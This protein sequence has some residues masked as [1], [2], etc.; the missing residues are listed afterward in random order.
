MSPLPSPLQAALLALGREGLAVS[1]PDGRIAWANPAF[2]ALWGADPVG[3]DLLAAL[4]PPRDEGDGEDGDEGATAADAAAWRTALARDLAARVAA[5]AADPAAGEAASEAAGRAAAEG[6]ARLQVGADGSPGIPVSWRLAAAMGH[7]LWTLSDL[8]PLQA[9]QAQAARGSALLEA[10]QEFG[11]LGV[12]ERDLRTGHGHWDRHVFR[13]FGL[14]PAQGTPSFEQAR[15]RIHPEDRG[16][17]DFQRSTTRPGR[18]AQRFRV[19]DGEGRLRWIHSQWEVV[20]DRRGRPRV[21]RGV[22]VDDSEAIAAARSLDE[23][24]AQLALALELG[25]IV[26][27]RHDLAS[28]RLYYNPRGYE[29]LAMPYRP[30]GLSLAEVR[31][32]IHP[33]DLPAVVDAAR[34][35]LVHDVPTDM[36]ARYRRSDGSWRHVLTRRVLQRDGAGRP[37]AFLGVALDI[38][39]QREVRQQA[40]RL[41]RQLENAASAAGIGM[42]TRD[43]QSDETHWDPETYRLYGRA[44]ALGP[45]SRE[46]WLQTYV[47]PDDRERMRALRARQLAAPEQVFEHEFRVI[48]GDG[49]LRWFAQRVRLEPWEGRALVF[50]ATLDVTERRRADQA[51]RDANDRVALATRAAG[52]GT[53]EV[54]LRSGEVRWDAQMYALRGLPA[55]AGEVAPALSPAQ[56]R[57]AL[58]HPDELALVLE[59]NRRS[60]E[61]GAM[62]S[63]EFRV[64]WP[65]GSYRWLASRSVPVYDDA[66]RAVRQIGVNLDIQE[67]VDAETA[68]REALAAQRQSE[69][70]SQFLARMSHELRTPLNAI[71]GFTQLLER[72]AEAGAAAEPAAQRLAKLRHVRQAADHLLALVNEVLDLARIESGTLQIEPVPVALDPLVAEVLDSLAA[73]AAAGGVVLVAET[74]GFGVRADRERLRQAL[75]RLLAHRIRHLAPGSQVRVAAA[76]DGS[77][78]VL[79]VADDGQALTADQQLQLF[80]AFGRHGPDGTDVAMSLALVKALLTSMAGRIEVDSAPGRGTRFMLWLPQA[81]VGAGIAATLAQAG[82]PGAEAA[83]PAPARPGRVLYIEDNTVNVL[84]VEELIAQ[85]GR[86]ELRSAPTGEAG[87]LEA[88]SWL[89]DL[90]LIDMQLPDFD[91]FEVLR[92]LRADTATAGLRCIALS[93]NAMPEDV[94]RALASGF[95]DYWTKP[96]RF[97]SFLAGLDALFPPA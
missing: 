73:E 61:R 29:V 40:D 64:R 14:D 85:R 32:L 35:A 20:A 33:D 6:R 60:I 90:V 56:L 18:Y 41:Q 46:D 65:D 54:D 81:A 39:R 95:D 22:M 70:K 49:E 74:A 12:W 36:A 23:A 55:P 5:A 26:V 59:A 16:A 27:W 53:W 78:A 31:A 79:A 13:F 10:A 11:R 67:S 88:R 1:T 83:D 76:G 15:Q 80:E 77:D 57:T 48:R 63:Y 9:A 96:I 82:Q 42:W 45:P 69:A 7:G 44:P 17:D 37:L 97:A 86:L 4:A 50:G 8:R 75:T 62:A 43:P 51:L 24:S 52:I 58:A 84:L 3:A 92:R 68:R 47:H 19:V 94:Q 87:V 25:E 2:A 34:E 91:G 66:G 71:L 28:D 38:T 21:A 30:E 89:P 93:A 72:D